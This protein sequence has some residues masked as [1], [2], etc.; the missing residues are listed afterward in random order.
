MTQINHLS[1]HPLPPPATAARLVSARE[2]VRLIRDGDTVATGGSVGIGFAEN[3]AVSD[4]VVF[5]E[6][7]Q[8]DPRASHPRDLTPGVRGRSGR[9]QG[10][11]A[12]TTS[13]MTD[14]WPAI[15]GHWG[16][17][18]KLQELAVSGRIEAW[19]TICRR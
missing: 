19:A 1:P 9:W 16:L 6:T 18:P 7:R 3:I 10:T 11:G 17:V 4:R 5:L 14:W 8:A 2:A 12:S 13:A 15:G